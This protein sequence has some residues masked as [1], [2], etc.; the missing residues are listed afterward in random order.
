VSRD[1]SAEKSTVEGQPSG[2][3]SVDQ[4]VSFKVVVADKKGNRVTSSPKGKEI[5]PFVVEISV[6]GKQ[7]QMVKIEENQEQEGILSFIHSDHYWSA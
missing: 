2:S 3:I 4:A 6:N 5:I 7:Q 1:I